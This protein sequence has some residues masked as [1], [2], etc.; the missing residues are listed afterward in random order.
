MAE[1]LGKHALECGP[2]ATRGFPYLVSGLLT[3]LSAFRT[4]GIME[5]QVRMTIEPAKHPPAG[6]PRSPHQ[7]VSV[8]PAL[9]ADQVRTLYS[10][11]PP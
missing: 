11:P 4:V 1:P 2:P 7:N 8:Y 3:S 5:Y 10:A 6:S 9:A